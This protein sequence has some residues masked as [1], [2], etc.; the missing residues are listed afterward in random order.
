MI[1]DLYCRLKEIKK[2]K[3]QFEDGR[4]DLKRLNASHKMDVD[5][6]RHNLEGLCSTLF[7]QIFDYEDY[8]YTP[9]HK[10][11]FEHNPYRDI[12]KTVKAISGSISDLQSTHNQV[13]KSSSLIKNIQR[14]KKLD[15]LKEE[16]SQLHGDSHIPTSIEDELSK[17]DNVIEATAN[18]SKDY[19]EA[20]T[21]FT[22]K[23]KTQMSRLAQYRFIKIVDDG[24]LRLKTRSKWPVV[25]AAAGLAALVTYSS[26][27]L[28][29]PIPK[30]PIVRMPIPKI[31][32][33]P[34]ITEPPRFEFDQKIDE[35]FVTTVLKGTDHESKVY[36]RKGKE[37]GGTI[38]LVSPHGDEPGSYLAIEELLKY[39]VKKGTVIYYPRTVPN[40]MKPG[41]QKRFLIEDLNRQFGP[42]SDDGT[43]IDRVAS[44]IKDLIEEYQPDLVM[45]VHEGSGFYSLG[46]RYGQSIVYDD[47]SQGEQ[48]DQALAVVNKQIN[49]SHHK[50]GK[51]LDPMPTTLTYMAFQQGIKAYGFE[52]SKAFRDKR[53]V[54]YHMLTFDA[55]AKQNG[56]EFDMDISSYVRYLNSFERPPKVKASKTI[57]QVGQDISISN[58]VSA[59]DPDYGREPKIAF[60]WI[61]NKNS[62]TKVKLGGRSLAVVNDYIGTNEVGY[63]VTDDEGH[64]V[65]GSAELIVEGR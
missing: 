62:E 20:I 46:G 15:N 18:L 40:C 55:F 57:A 65:R 50:Y 33:E 28:E 22:E 38:L 23:A 7:H 13:L 61:Y 9:L 21:H 44:V 10:R 5:R 16:Y 48:I 37:K 53:S 8:R 42:D 29:P 39:P 24:D 6:N 58:L 1:K 32:P 19:S 63:R 47:A 34:V 4:S 14:K 60:D 3:G 54:S 49:I 43:I 56:V 52:T 30:P 64:V 31:E 26:I 12:K 27:D 25:V 2:K 36:M 59:K 11:L 45:N 41:S 17:F 35:H 51:K